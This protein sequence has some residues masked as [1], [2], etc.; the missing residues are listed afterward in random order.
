MLISADCSVSAR[1]RRRCVL[2][3]TLT[4]NHLADA[5]L[6]GKTPRVSLEFSR[7]NVNVILALLRSA[8][9]GK[10]ELLA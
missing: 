6:L 2:G 9:T 5:I 1:V 7:G 3:S 8:Q 4:A 10:P